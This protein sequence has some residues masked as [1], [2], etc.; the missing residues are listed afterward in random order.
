MHIDFEPGGFVPSATVDILT[1][2]IWEHRPHS[3]SRR[4]PGFNTVKAV[5]CPR[6]A[7]G[8]MKEMEIDL[9][10]TQISVKL[11]LM[12]KTW[13]EDCVITSLSGRLDQGSLL[14]HRNMGLKSI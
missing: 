4:I 5:P 2:Y 14:C 13:K 6:G 12:S 10:I 8:L 9:V 7:Y 3:G 1:A 11:P